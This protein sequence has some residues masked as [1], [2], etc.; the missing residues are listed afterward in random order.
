MARK[1]TSGKSKKDKGLHTRVVVL[2]SDDQQAWLQAQSESTGAP[3]ANIVRRA[4][5]EY[6]QRIEKGK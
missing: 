2:M 1:V 5:D 3:I 6:R 4:V